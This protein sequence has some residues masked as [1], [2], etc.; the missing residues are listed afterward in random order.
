MFLR[1][2]HCCYSMK[3]WKN[4]WHLSKPKLKQVSIKFNFLLLFSG[5]LIQIFA[6]CL[7]GTYRTP[8][9]LKY[10]D[11]SLLAPKLSTIEI[12]LEDGPLLEKILQ[13]L[14]RITSTYQKTLETVSKSMDLFCKPLETLNDANEVRMSTVLFESVARNLSS[15]DTSQEKKILSKNIF[16]SL[17]ESFEKGL[18]NFASN[19]LEMKCLV[20]RAF[21]SVLDSSHPESSDSIKKWMKHAPKFTSFC[22]QVKV[23]FHI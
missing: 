15:K 10:V 14:A 20:L 11:F 7:D 4:W 5:H 19:C 17:C 21:N 1:P 9:V 2:T 12:Q 23:T 16:D 6:R 3:Y 18:K 8:S 13:S 22:L